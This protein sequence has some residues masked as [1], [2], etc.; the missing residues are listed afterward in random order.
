MVAKTEDKEIA[1]KTINTT[2]L[3]TKTNFDIKVIETEHKIPDD[4]TFIKIE[5]ILALH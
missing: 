1:N 4:A 3:V 5:Y 2:G